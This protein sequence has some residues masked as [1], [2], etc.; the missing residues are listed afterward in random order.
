MVAGVDVR[1]RTSALCLPRSTT[2]DLG[3]EPAEDDAVGVDDVAIRRWI[4]LA[5]GV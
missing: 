2:G 4:S 1:W 5:F 3:G